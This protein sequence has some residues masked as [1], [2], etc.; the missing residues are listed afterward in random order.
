MRAVCL[1][2]LLGLALLIAAGCG[3]DDDE[4][5]DPP[6][7]T[8]GAPPGAVTARDAVQTYLDIDRVGVGEDAWVSL[9][10]FTDVPVQI[11]GLHLCQGSNCE[12]LPERI[13]EPGEN[14]YVVVSG[15]PALDGLAMIDDA[16]LGELRPSDGELSLFSRPDFDD[17][18]ALVLFL[19]WGST[20]HE[21][22]DLALEAGLWVEGA[23]APSTDRATELFRQETG[24]WLFREG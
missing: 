12:E 6:A 24:L 7:V 18:S 3:G 23:F 9:G 4:E 2:I 14:V 11:G 5:V 19:E 20:P 13:V 10:N 16:G 1:A 8:T 21:H 17:P 15:D 22:T